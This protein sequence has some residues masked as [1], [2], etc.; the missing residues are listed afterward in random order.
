MSIRIC[1]GFLLIKNI[2][3]NFYQKKEFVCSNISSIFLALS[4]N[5]PR[6]CPNSTWNINATSIA[7]Q[8]I[9]NE[10]SYNIFINSK[11]TIYVVPHKSLAI[12]VWQNASSIGPPK[13]IQG[14]LSVTSI[15]VT[16]N[17][18]IYVDNERLSVDIDKWIAAN[19]T[20]ITVMPVE[21][22]CYD[23]FIDICDNLYCSLRLKN[24][25][26][27]KWSS[28]PTTIVAGTGV[29]G[30]TSDRLAFSCGIFVDTNL[31]LYVADSGNNRIQ[32]FRLNH[33]YGITV[34]GNGSS[35]LTIELRRPTD[36]VLDS[37]QHVF[38]VDSG[39]NRIVGSDENGFRCIFGC[40]S[41]PG[42]TDDKLS[43][44]E[45]MSFDSHGNIYVTDTNNE[46]IQKIHL[47]QSLCRKF[48]YMICHR[49]KI[50]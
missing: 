36:V 14:S 16:S 18:D 2:I 11:D 1:I 38:I 8:Y 31:D 41:R 6:F 33:Q 32:L 4:F 30:S 50:H 17:D 13:R 24:K 22:R 49:I 39:N 42:S 44:P 46:R 47:S 12:Y 23:L 29:Y 26:A 27:K 15:F 3:G 10:Q 45:S 7:K 34:A 40:S 9:I 21:G 37:N 19:E 35:Q 25:V 48:Q 28:G 43:Y 5:Q 20:W